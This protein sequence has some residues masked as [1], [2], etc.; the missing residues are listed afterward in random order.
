MIIKIKIK[1]LQIVD[2]WRDSEWD[3]KETVDV[4]DSWFYSQ[5]AISSRKEYNTGSI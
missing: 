3:A 2:R 5:V 1:K 4:S